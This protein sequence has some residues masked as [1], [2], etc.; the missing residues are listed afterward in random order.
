MLMSHGIDDMV[1]SILPRHHPIRTNVSVRRYT[2]DFLF[3][4]NHWRPVDYH[5]HEVSL[6]TNLA[7]AGLLTAFSEQY[8]RGYSRNP[9]PHKVR[10][11][12]RA[13]DRHRSCHSAIASGSWSGLHH[14]G[15]KD[16]GTRATF[17]IHAVEPCTIDN[18][19]SP[20]VQN[21]PAIAHKDTKRT[22]YVNTSNDVCGELSYWRY[23]HRRNRHGCSSRSISTVFERDRHPAARRLRRIEILHLQSAW[24]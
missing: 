14:R 16:G 1:F 9:S 4:Q 19:V 6:C 2:D 20:T 12:A 3:G 24:G 7:G 18:G 21:D 10:A 23:K 13:I 15:P 22:G 8:R 17:H 5:S 11:Q